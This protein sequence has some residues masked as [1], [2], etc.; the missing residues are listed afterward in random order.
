MFFYISQKD[1]RLFWKPSKAIRIQK[2]RGAGF[3]I[4]NL[5]LKMKWLFVTCSSFLLQFPFRT[6]QCHMNKETIIKMLIEMS[7][8]TY[9]LIELSK[10]NAED[11][12]DITKAAENLYEEFLSSEGETPEDQF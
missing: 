10:E 2:E 12:Y 9:E 6:G 1:S 8:R 3:F 4:I 5:N 7:V 11:E